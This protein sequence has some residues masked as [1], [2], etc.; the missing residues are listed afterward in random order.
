MPR[1]GHGGWDS[2]G[3]HRNL[4]NPTPFLRAWEAKAAAVLRQG[5]RTVILLRLFLGFPEPQG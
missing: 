3:R 2:A 5:P 1:E 4:A